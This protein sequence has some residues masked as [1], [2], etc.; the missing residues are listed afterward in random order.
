MNTSKSN[1]V[2]DSFA[3]PSACLCHHRTDFAYNRHFGKLALIHQA[4]K[5]EKGYEN[6]LSGTILGSRAMEDPLSNLKCSLAEKLDLGKSQQTQGFFSIRRC[7]VISVACSFFY[8]CW[9]PE[10]ATIDAR[11]HKLQRQLLWRCF[12]SKCILPC[13]QGHQQ[14]SRKSDENKSF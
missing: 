14:L 4:Y 13:H 5:Q 3:L 12:G 7:N 1:Q 6:F 9:K 10:Y 11:I 8:R 2:F